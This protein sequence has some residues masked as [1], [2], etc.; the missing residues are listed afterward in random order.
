MSDELR[1][2]IRKMYIRSLTRYEQ[3]YIK[4]PDLCKE[5]VD[6]FEPILNAWHIRERRKWAKEKVPKEKEMSS[7]LGQIDEVDIYRRGFNQCRKET[8]KKIEES[9]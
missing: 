4:P 5:V 3:I 2:I 1:E 6:T 7:Y 8:L 9:E